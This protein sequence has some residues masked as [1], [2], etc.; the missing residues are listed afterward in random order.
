MDDCVQLQQDLHSLEI[1]EKDWKMEFNIAKCNVLRIIIRRVPI[2]FNYTLHG[3]YLDEIASTKYLGVYLF[4]DL[5]WNE[6]VRYITNKANKLLGFLNRNLK[7]CTTSTKKNAYKS[8]FQPIVEYCSS[9]WDCYTAKN[10]KQVE[11]VQRRAARW[12]LSRYN[13]QD[14]ATDISAK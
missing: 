6:H 7:H 14:S 9:V 8:L 13:R 5:R 11:M 2:I 12:I 4:N 1:W 3:C 10:I